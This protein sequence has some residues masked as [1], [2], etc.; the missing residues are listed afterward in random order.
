MSIRTAISARRWVLCAATGLFLLRPI[1]LVAQSAQD[2]NPQAELKSAVQKQLDALYSKE[3]KQAPNMMPAGKG[4]QQPAP[5]PAIR[6]TAQQAAPRQQA[7][8]PTRRATT[9]P[10]GSK[11]DI[12]RKLEEM[13]A[14]DGRE[15]PQ[16]NT[17]EAVESIQQDPAAE[18]ESEPAEVVVD[19]PEKP[20]FMQRMNPFKSRAKAPA[21]KQA[22]PQQARRPSRL[23]QQA[24]VDAGQPEAPKKSRFVPAFM[25]K[26]EAEA[27]KEMP[28]PRTAESIAGRPQRSPQAAAP[29]SRPQMRTRATRI[30]EPVE[31]NVATSEP[32]DSSQELDNSAPAW[33]GEP[34]KVAE[35]PGRSRASAKAAPPT[36]SVEIE[37]KPAVA[38]KAA[39][40]KSLDLDDEDDEDLDLDDEMEEE[41]VRVERAPKPSAKELLESESPKE[42]TPVAKTEVVKDEPQEPVSSAPF[43]EDFADPFTEM[44]EKVAD[45]SKDSPKVAPVK[46]VDKKPE[47]AEE[48][49]QVQ[50]ADDNPFTGLTLD[51][52]TDVRSRKSAKGIEAPKA[53]ELKAPEQ[54]AD[55]TPA[56]EL[57]TAAE[58]KSEPELEAPAELKTETELRPSLDS[59]GEPELAAEQ[60]SV[61]VMPRVE[62]S[63]PELQKVP[64]ATAPKPLPTAKTKAIPEVEDPLERAKLR[65]LVSRRGLVGLKGF[66]PVALRERRDLVDSRAEFSTTHEGKTYQF[67]SAEAKTA[68]EIEPEK[69]VPV[70]GGIDVVVEANSHQSVEGSLDQAVWF[71]DRLY[72][73][74]SAE[75]ME[76]FVLNPAE[77]VRN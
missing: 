33:D 77:Y 10:S 36:E 13:Y 37:E 29:E 76:A 66:C 20:S 54:A 26:K 25:R 8:A 64:E 2:A 72:L 65:R 14:R 53:S 62:A 1:S 42:K 23:P 15:M 74:S 55:S 24:Q 39:V 50:Q 35:A 41:L 32:S 48:K 71:R 9:Q 52:T 67:S 19:E 43:V 49:K 5:A 51:E 68:F 4:T 3:G 58:P 28:Q 47:A 27:P 61:P 11:S 57:K 30:D 7:A 22:P 12:Q 73:F 59:K 75:S 34:A 16:M 6:Q 21:K 45:G 31:S 60:K 44:S 70:K 17:A 40:K 63:A 56:L 38:R 69:F 18:Q 46:H